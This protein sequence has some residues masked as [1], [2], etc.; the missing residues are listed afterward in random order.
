MRIILLAAS[1][2]ILA[3]CAMTSMNPNTGQ[4]A[5]GIAARDEEPP[6]PPIFRRPPPTIRN[7]GST[8]SGGMY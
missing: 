2:A 6:V 7:W 4:Q 3:G 1:A 5:S 8:G